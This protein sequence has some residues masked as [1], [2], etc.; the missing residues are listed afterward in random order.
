MSESSNLSLIFHGGVGSVTGSN[1]ELSD[2]ESNGKRVLVDCGL[3]QGSQVDPE[4]NHKPFA[5]YPSEIDALFVTHAHL[6]HIGRIPKL[7]RDGFRGEIYSTPPTRKMSELSLF[8]SL[9][10]MSKEARSSNRE[11][12]YQ[13]ADVKQALNQWQVIDYHSP[14]NVGRL[15]FHLSNA[16]HILGSATVTAKGK[17]RNVVL[18]GDLGNDPSV[19]LPA[20]EAVTEADYMVIESVYG[21]REHEG[22]DQR[23]F[24][25]QRIISETM[26]AGGTLMIPAFSIERTQEVLLTIEELMD[27]SEI[28][29]VPVYL[30]SPLAI[31]MTEIY[32]EYS[33][34]FKHRVRQKADGGSDIF[35]FP[36][37]N[38]T[39][40]TE[41]SKF[42]AGAP[43]RKIVIAGSGMSNGGRILHHE[44]NYLPDPKSTLLLVGYQSPG[45]LGR[46]LEDGAKTVKIMGETVPVRAKI[47]RI[48][49]YSAHMDSP[50]LLDYVAESEKTLRKVFVAMGEPKSSLFLVQ[51]IR[52]YLGV[53]AI[54]PRLGHE[55]KLK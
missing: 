3:V 39:E 19:L 32:S 28:P 5:Y 44:K 29:L 33:D 55:E 35:A 12:L 51:R 36:Q 21:D 6:D 26:K 38:K 40:T 7:V 17:G 11:L 24:H 46:M 42:I 53:E 34:Y 43:A 25:L 15:A 41:E 20:P 14:V 45:S 50:S 27:R 8:D 9:G 54:M 52:D 18:T 22:Q 47:E 13:E 16:G 10:V 31:G 49:G 1:F 2:P 37:L 48:S 4:E 30:D 23:R